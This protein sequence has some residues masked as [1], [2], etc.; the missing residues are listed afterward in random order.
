MK[1]L[2]QRLA[3]GFLTMGR[4]F[5]ASEVGLSLRPEVERGLQRMKKM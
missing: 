2:T 1:Q 5:Q 3:D 4:V